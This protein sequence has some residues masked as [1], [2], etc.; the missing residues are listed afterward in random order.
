MDNELIEENEDVLQETQ[1][2]Q[3]T[4]I[5]QEYKSCV[6]CERRMATLFFHGNHTTCHTCRGVDAYGDVL[7]TYTKEKSN[8]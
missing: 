8:D 3:E 6:G 5:Y 2:Y 1:E 7:P 4:P